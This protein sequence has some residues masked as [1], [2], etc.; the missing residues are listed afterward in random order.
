MPYRAN[1]AGI[2]LVEALMTVAI[3]AIVTSLAIPSLTDLVAVARIKDAAMDVLSLHAQARVEAIRRGAV[4]AVN[5]D[6]ALFT[7]TAADGT[8]LLTRHK[9]EGL[10][11]VGGSAA[12]YNGIGRLVGEFT[13]L[14]IGGGTSSAVRCITIEK[15]G[16]GASK[17]DVCRTE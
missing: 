2:T 4:V 6:A 12:A 15:S 10:S 8:R 1:Q 13:P 11:F 17:S 7:V 16:R 5:M 9:P 3:S 14:Q